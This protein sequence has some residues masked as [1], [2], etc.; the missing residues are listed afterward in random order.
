MPG[1]DVALD[2]V[3]PAFVI[4]ERE[5]ARSSHFSSSCMVRLL[6]SRVMNSI[7]TVKVFILR[8]SVGVVIA[9]LA[10]NRPR[11]IPVMFAIC[12]SL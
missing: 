2:I 6:G 11:V 10:P 4:A 7:V 1:L 5:G 3:L 8:K 12:T 9:D